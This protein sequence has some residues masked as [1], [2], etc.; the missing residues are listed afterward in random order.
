MFF[1]IL[2]EYNDRRVLSEKKRHQVKT[3]GAYIRARAHGENKMRDSSVA[4]RTLHP[5]RVQAVGARSPTLLFST[6]MRQRGDG[7]RIKT[8]TTT[9]NAAYVGS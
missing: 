8:S 4:A 1:H 5:E 6:A 7:M 2:S 9:E 3:F